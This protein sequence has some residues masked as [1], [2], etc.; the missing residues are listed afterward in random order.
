MLFLDQKYDSHKRTPPRHTILHALGFLAIAVLEYAPK[1]PK[2]Y[3]NYYGPYVE[4]RSQAVTFCLFFALRLARAS[5][6][7]ISKSAGD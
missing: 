4:P 1:P 5:P 6:G 3:C 7:A 2:S